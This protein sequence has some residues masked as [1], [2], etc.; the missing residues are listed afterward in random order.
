MS[1]S[2]RFSLHSMW[3]EWHSTKY[4]WHVCKPIHAFWYMSYTW[5]KLWFHLVCSYFMSHRS[6]FRRNEI[7]RTILVFVFVLSAV[8]KIFDMRLWNCLLSYNFLTIMKNDQPLH[9][10]LKRRAQFHFFLR[11]DIEG[12]VFVW[13][14]IRKDKFNEM[15]P[16]W[17][18]FIDQIH[19]QSRIICRRD[20]VIWVVKMTCF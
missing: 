11:N 12:E 13:W 16:Y 15:L 7:C 10:S 14:S 5:H 6:R 4:K 9:P 19:T 18:A 17:N 2:K 3:N 8:Q 20:A 1:Y